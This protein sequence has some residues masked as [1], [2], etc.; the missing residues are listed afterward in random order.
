MRELG[1]QLTE[2]RD[3]LGLNPKEAAKLIGI[4]SESL[5]KFEWGFATPNAV[6]RTKLANFYKV[7]VQD[8]LRLE[9]EQRVAKQLSDRR[10]IVR[11]DIE[12]MVGAM[13]LQDLEQLFAFAKYIQADRIIAKGEKNGI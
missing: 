2:E 13:D 8:L 5:T 3:L 11:S 12:N 4:P 7:D 10:M 1:K 6:Q 9:M